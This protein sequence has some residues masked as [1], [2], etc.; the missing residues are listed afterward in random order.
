MKQREANLSAF[1]RQQRGK[2][3]RSG[4]SETSEK[5]TEEADG[6]KQK[7]SEATDVE[8]SKIEGAEDKDTPKPD[9][10]TYANAQRH[11]IV[12]TS[13]LIPSPTPISL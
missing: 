2:R 13:P 8:G 10:E 12:N 4:A 5:K 6:T 7:G 3:L 1:I 9:A 11:I